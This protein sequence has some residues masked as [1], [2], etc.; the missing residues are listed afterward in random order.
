MAGGCPTH[1]ER[2]ETPGGIGNRTGWAAT[3]HVFGGTFAPSSILPHFYG[4]LAG[5]LAGGGPVNYHAMAPLGGI[6]RTDKIVESFA[7]IFEAARAR[8]C[9]LRVAGHSLGGVVAWALAHEYQDVVDVVEVW[10][11]PVRGTGVAWLFH[12][13]GAEA[14]FL[15]PGSRW[16][17]RYDRPLNGPVVRSMYTACDLFVV[18]PRQSSYVEGDR[19]Q[20]H[21]LSPFLFHRSNRRPSERV[22]TGWADHLLLPRHATLLAA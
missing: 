8:E 9:R 18:P 12:H 20:N 2:R 6:G 10:A 11:T 21:L 19:A 15:A 4:R 17:K 3:T 13:L 7:P 22:H 16:L 14:R 1:R 5:R